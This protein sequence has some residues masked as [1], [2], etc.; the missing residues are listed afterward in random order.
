[1]VLSETFWIAF[2]STASASCLITVRWCYRSKCSHIT[3]CGIDIQR[4]VRGEEAVDMI[5]PPSPNN[6][7]KMER[8]I[9]L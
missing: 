9:S 3:F 8:T 4:D 5:R 1:M 6:S 2:V 7:N